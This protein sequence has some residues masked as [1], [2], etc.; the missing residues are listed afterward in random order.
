[1]EIKF[2]GITK[3]KKLAMDIKELSQ[4]F[5]CCTRKLRFIIK[6]KKV[7]KFLR[8]GGEK[9]ANPTNFVL[10]V[11]QFPK[12]KLIRKI[13]GNVASGGLVAVASRLLESFNSVSRSNCL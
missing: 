7:G 1:M 3:G 10:F 11:P 2:G 8:N 12:Q 4:L 6:K 5:T 9:W 13:S